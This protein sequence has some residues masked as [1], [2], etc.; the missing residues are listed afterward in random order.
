MS[1]LFNFIKNQWIMGKSQ[2]YVDS[3]FAKGYITEEEKVTILSIP[4][5]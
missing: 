2:A 5:V 3:A 1:P 4:Q